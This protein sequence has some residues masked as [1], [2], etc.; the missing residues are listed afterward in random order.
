MLQNFQTFQKH[1]FTDIFEIIYPS[2]LILDNNCQCFCAILLY[3]LVCAC[4]MIV[5]FSG[6]YFTL[7][8]NALHSEDFNHLKKLSIKALTTERCI[9]VPCKKTFV[10]LNCQFHVIL[11]YFEPWILNEYFK[12]L[13]T[14]SPGCI[15]SQ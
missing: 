2:P 4:A 13:T 5:Y 14:Q 12:L 7:R 15:E 9:G 11:H 6:P 3:L 8:R 1:T 10:Y